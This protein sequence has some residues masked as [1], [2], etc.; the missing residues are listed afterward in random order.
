MISKCCMHWLKHKIPKM[1][2]KISTPSSTT[3]TI[4][5]V[6]RKPAEWSQKNAQFTVVICIC[7]AAIWPTM[8]ATV[9][10][11]TNH[12]ATCALCT[13]SLRVWNVHK[14]Q[15]KT[16]NTSLEITDYNIKHAL[17]IQSHQPWQIPESDQRQP[18]SEKASLVK[19]QTSH[20]GQQST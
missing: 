8:Q 12:A 2:G 1:P 20:S 11:T 18:Q 16:N 4:K 7:A 6:L 5:R 9:K 14:K 3:S 13:L 17:K 19:I 15:Q 10:Q